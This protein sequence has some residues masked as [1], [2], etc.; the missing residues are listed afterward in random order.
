MAEEIEIKE[1]GR[2]N[3]GFDDDITEETLLITI[4][5][6]DDIDD[7]S[8]SSQPIET[9]YNQ[10]TV[11]KSKTKSIWPEVKKVRSEI[12]IDEIENFKKHLRL[13]FD[14]ILESDKFKYDIH[15]KN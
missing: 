10:T 4:D 3:E 14:A 1:F 13:D 12:K 2:D 6:Y 7:A 9:F 8:D 5:D 15:N 11:Q